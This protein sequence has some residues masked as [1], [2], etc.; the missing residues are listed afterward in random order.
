MHNSKHPQEG[1]GILYIVATPIGNLEDITYRAV[2]ILKEVDYIAS[3]DT[4]HTRKLTSHFQIQTN[5]ISYYREKEVQRSKKIIEL[6]LGGN[7]IALVSDA[8]IPCVSDPGFILVKQAMLQS[9][10]VVTIPGPSAVVSAIS[11][12]GLKSDQF[13]FIGFLPSKK[14][15]RIKLLNTNKLSTFLL[16]FYESPRRII[17]SLIDCLEVFGD[18]QA[19][20]CKELTKIYEQSLQGSLSELVEYFSAKAT[21][22]GEYVLLIE[23]HDGNVAPET[24]DM[25][26]LLSWFRDNGELSMKDAVKKLS[27]D[28]GVSRSKVYAMALKVW[29]KIS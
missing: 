2:R 27:S 18:R 16:V 9:I 19:A 6:L 23:G 12:A 3:E 26:E 29:G 15:E 24:E 5:L 21:I 28:M 11:I 14:G 13:A 1:S 17:S 22:K 20:V 4:R 8:G 7:N 10:K 25:V